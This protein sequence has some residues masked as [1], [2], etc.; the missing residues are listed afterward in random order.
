MTVIQFPVFVKGQTLTDDDLNDLRDSLEEIDRRTGRSIGF[1]INCGLGGSIAANILTIENGIAIDQLGQ[2][3]ELDAPFTVGLAPTASP[4]EPPAFIDAAPGGFT[5]V[6]HLASR[7]LPAPQCNEAGCEGHAKQREVSSAVTIFGGRLKDAVRDFGEE[8]LLDQEP[9]L[10][11]KTGTVSGGFIALKTAIVNRMGDR[12]NA[13]ARTKLSGMTIDSDLPAIQGFKASFL[14]QVLFASLDLLRCEFEI[15]GA[16]VTTQDGIGVALGWLHRNGTGWSWDC[17]FRHDW[18][19][20]T[21]VALA[22]LGGQCSDP[23]DLYREQ[24]N[25]LINAFE[26][27]LTPAPPDDPDDGP[28]EIC[29][30]KVGSRIINICERVVD[31]PDRR[32]A[33]LREIY[34]EK[35]PF[36]PRKPEKTAELVYELPQKDWAEAG[37][38]SL[39]GAVGKKT[40]NVITEL[41]T[42]LVDK[43]NTAPIQV[44]S[45]NQVTKLDGYQAG[46]TVSAADTV[47][48][49]E[50]GLKKVVG[51]GSIPANTTM[52]GAVA[53]VPRVA[54]LAASAETAAKTALSTTTTFTNRLNTVDD[55][56]KGF[57][58]FQTNIL[59]WQSGI[60]GRVGGL[61]SEINS[62]ALAAVGQY[63]L[64][65]QSEIDERIG[66]AVNT[67]RVGLVDQVRAEMQAV[68]GQVKTDVTKDFQAATT[69]LRKEVEA[70]QKQLTNKV[71]DLDQ[72]VAALSGEVQVATRDADRSNQRIDTV[73]T[74]TRP[75]VGGIGGVRTVDRPLVDVIGN[76]RTAIVAAATPAQRPKVNAALAESEDAFKALSEATAAGPVELETQRVALG[77]V[78]TSMTTAVEAAGA[79]AADVDRLRVDLE[80]VINR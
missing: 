80:R 79:P 41:T 29:Y 63:Q 28:V 68:G 54:G 56:L 17:R 21:G 61:T 66:V 55:T 4:D 40:A 67:L 27:P 12:L 31:A 47:V 15:S 70:D 14:N 59:S 44:V 18:D 49:V 76:M 52:R 38:I 19:V 1:G 43:G 24:L 69:T 58:T 9:L 60:D 65:M 62:K 2:V 50:D 13:D 78:L 53:E 22:L 25:A 51:V 16:C 35:V 5:P 6:L 20:P 3:L 45:Q 10:V 74:R 72:H 39:K 8:P 42:V 64:A 57:T 32:E 36:P 37:T 7:D 26:V 71:G 75:D 33:D 77:T 73:L 30:R 46:I 23:C 48:L 34:R 11:R